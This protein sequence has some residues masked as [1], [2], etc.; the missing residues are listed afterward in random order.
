MGN[1]RIYDRVHG[2]MH[3]PAIVTRVA[4][5]P[6]VRRLDTIRQLGGCALLYPSATHT[7]LE[8]SYGVAHLA[9]VL[10]RRLRTQR[11]DLVREDDIVALQLAGLLHDVGHG[12]LSH[13]FEEY[14][15][16]HHDPTWC[17]E[18]A[19]QQLS[20]QAL[21]AAGVSD[22]SLVARVLTMIDGLERCQPLPDACGPMQR[23]LLDIVHDRTHGIDVDKL[24]YLG[25]DALAVFGATKAVD[26]T[27]ILEAA[28]IVEYDGEFHIA[29]DERVALSLS[30]VYALRARMHKQVYQH[31]RVILAEARLRELMKARWHRTVETVT[32]D[33]LM[34]LCDAS[35]LT[36]PTTA[37]TPAVH[38]AYHALFA[39]AWRVPLTVCL[40]TL[41]RCGHCDAE[42]HILDAF[43]GACGTSTVSRLRT[44]V[45][46]GTVRMS[47]ACFLTAQQATED[48][49]RMMVE[50]ALCVRP[51]V[52][53]VDVRSGAASVEYDPHGHAWRTYD[54]LINVLFT[55]ETT[56]RVFRMR[57][58]AFTAPLVRHVRIA[59]VYLDETPDE[60]DTCAI[61]ECVRRWAKRRG[62][63]VEVV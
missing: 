3:F 5:T 43:C 1:C 2:D 32:V 33:W 22:P 46:N 60:D 47:S 41:P 27:R 25:R 49:A 4:N 48:L 31:R 6:Q 12:P 30:E 59:H 8:H 21:S 19:G 58:D 51:R 52:L 42:T 10:G 14:V 9:G 18:V 36:P 11:P 26:T 13:L 29:Y 50:S 39:T 17:H 56:S 16:L 55:N 44:S 28:H 20:R 53:I 63:V 54:P 61:C 40:P 45:L 37:D 15:Q 35:L 23:F 62:S 57:A 7:R 24:D 34:T 38:V